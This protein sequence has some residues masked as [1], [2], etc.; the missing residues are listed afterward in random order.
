M[1]KSCSKQFDLK[2]IMQQFIKF[3]IVG[4]SNTFIS[5]LIF[6]LLVFL[7][8]HYILANTLAFIISVLN[9]YYWN[10]KYVFNK[11]DKR[12]QTLTKTFIS[13]GTTF[14]LGTF[15]LFV[16]VE[17]LNVSQLIAPLVNLLITVPINFLFN[18]FWAFK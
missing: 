14:V 7:H 1:K 18:K 11:T 15:L 3:G 4:I 13:Y 5:L 12:I 9:S 10:R 6:Y 8:F 17:K 2:N 16:M